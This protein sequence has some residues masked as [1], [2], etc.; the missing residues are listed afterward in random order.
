[1]S[2]TNTIKAKTSKNTIET[3][4]ALLNTGTHNNA[5]ILDLPC[6]SGALS[7]RLVKSKKNYTVYAGDI[8]RLGNYQDVVFTITD[9]NEPLAYAD[10]FFDAIVCGDGI[11]HLKKPFDFVS[12]CHRVLKADG[13]LILS[14]PNLSSLQSRFRYFMTG[15]HNK[16][17]VPFNE[18]TYSPQHIVNALDFPDLRYLLHSNGFSI[19]SI[20][21]NRYKAS[22]LFYVL[23]LPFILGFTIF[24]FSKE[25]GQKHRTKE[26]Q[27]L[28]KA[29]FKQMFK[30]EVL[31]GETLIL[32]LK[33]KAK[34]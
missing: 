9:M 23:F 17:K 11:A 7:H 29:V 31:F 3:L 32:K 24:S 14:T 21:T 8:E 6:G 4:V 16:R 25:L 20:H 15:F 18:K 2:D 1:M 28:Y 5:V 26:D 27:K 10:N 19:H 33:L 22:S 12:E 34:S 13:N 30:I